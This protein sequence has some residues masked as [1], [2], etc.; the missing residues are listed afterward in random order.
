M[1]L[2]CML[3]T[4]DPLQLEGFVPAAILRW[5]HFIVS[6]RLPYYLIF[7]CSLLFF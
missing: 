3:L 6:M 1:M 2:V 7:I 4:V 5:V